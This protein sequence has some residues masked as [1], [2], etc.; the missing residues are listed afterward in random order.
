MFGN[1]IL[2]KVNQIGT[3]TETFEA[4]EMAKERVI[5]QSS[6]TVVVNLKIQL[7]QILLLQR[8]Q[9]KLKQV[10]HLEPIVLQNTIS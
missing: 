6:H 3:L 2:V 4:I 10:V 7:L 1:S 8:M 5:Q 9:D